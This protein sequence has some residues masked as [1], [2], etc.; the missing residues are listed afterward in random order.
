[1]DPGMPARRCQANPKVSLETTMMAESPQPGKKK[2]AGLW[3]V[4][5]RL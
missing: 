3:H 2:E 1:M 4:L 5:G